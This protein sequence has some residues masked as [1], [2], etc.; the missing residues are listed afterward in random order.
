MARAKRI[1]RIALTVSDLEGA[2]AFYVSA[3]GFTKVAERVQEGAA[4]ELLTGLGGARAQVAVLRLAEQEIELAAFSPAGAPFSKPM[5]ANDPSFQHFAIAVYDMAAA[6]AQLSGAAQTAISVGGPQR[7]PPSTG[8]VTAYKFRDPEGHPLEL[9]FIPDSDWTSGGASPTFRGVDH[10]ALAVSDL[11]A[12]TAFY[13]DLIGLQP[14]GRGLNQGP[15]QDRLD[16]LTQ[17]ALEISVL[18]SPRPGPHIEL[19]H[20]RA[21]RAVQPMTPSRPNDVG[22]TRTVI[23]VEAFGA[24]LA[25]LSQARVRL[26]SVE[27]A[28]LDGH[29][30]A[31]IQDLDGHLLQLIG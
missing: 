12:S 30:Q 21:P 17:V 9:S 10:T 4:F 18:R 7:L 27:P 28:I 25:D 5:A 11:E 14:S 31:I 23:E 29:S 3:L 22:A 13:R 1:A 6:Y 16:G 2:C 8:S 19:L 20:Y 15:E 24:I 26:V